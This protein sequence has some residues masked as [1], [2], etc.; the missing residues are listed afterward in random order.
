MYKTTHFSYRDVRLPYISR[1]DT[2]RLLIY[3]GMHGDEYEVISSVTKAFDQFES[4]LP[5]FIFIPQ[6]SPSAVTQ[7]TRYNK[8][9]TDVNR[10]FFEGTNITEAQALMELVRQYKFDVCW[11][12][13]E[14]PLLDKFYLYD[15]G[16]MLNDF[17]W[18]L[19]TEKLRQLGVELFTGIDDPNDSALGYEII[20]GYISAPYD[21]TNK[22]IM[23][24]TFSEWATKRSIVKRVFNPEIPG[25]APQTIKDKVVELIFTHFIINSDQ[26]RKT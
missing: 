5:N 6:A 22:K 17:R 14:D 16:N 9:K 13:H 7:K 12:F 25:K 20:E 19:F 1:G 21:L 8:D 10:S 11:E 24:G 18:K 15:N 26:T 23:I 3:S 2:P 4:Q